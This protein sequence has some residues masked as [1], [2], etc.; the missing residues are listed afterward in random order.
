MENGKT[1][2]EMSIDT[3]A[4]YDLLLKA[5]PGQTVT[6]VEM[7]NLLGRDVAGVFP[8]LQ[9]ALRRVENLDGIVFGNVRGIGYKRLNDIEIIQTSEREIVAIRRRA[10]KAGR[11]VTKIENFDAL[12]NEEKIRHNMSLSLFGA[13]NSMT[14]PKQ[15]RKLEEA[16]SSAAKELPIGRTLE[17][18]K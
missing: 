2:F 13:I 1:L 17:V 3:R 18:F 11:R 16:V 4:L 15:V 8:N 5:D 9:S 14:K 6:F 12:P 10:R 7:T